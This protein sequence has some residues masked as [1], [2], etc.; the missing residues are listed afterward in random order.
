M[1]VSGGS[2][3]IGKNG[4]AGSQPCVDDSAWGTADLRLLHP[5]LSVHCWP[6]A[7]EFEQ[8]ELAPV[9]RLPK[10]RFCPGAICFSPNPCRCPNNRRS[11]PFPSQPTTPPTRSRRQPPRRSLPKERPPACWMP[12]SEPDVHDLTAKKVRQ[13][14]KNLPEEPSPVGKSRLHG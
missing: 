13:A 7:T 12:R 14:P 9:R 3:L 8:S 1:S 6:A 4:A 11:R 10:N 5:R 2:T